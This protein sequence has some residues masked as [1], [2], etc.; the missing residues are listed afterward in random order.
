MSL[1]T[2]ESVPRHLRFNFA[3][4]LLDGAFFGLG[5]GFG[6]FVAIVPLFVHHLTKSALL[7][8]LVPAI[9][10][11]GWQLPQLLTAGWLTRAKRYKPLTLLMTVHE[12]VPF[13]GLSLL[14]L[15]VPQTSKTT[16][17]LLTF[18]MLVWQGLGAGMAANPWT[19]LVSKVIP[20]DLHGTFFG[21]QS[22]AFNGLAG[23]SALVASLILSSCG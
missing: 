11:M 3:V 7:I 9:H 13:L 14:A 22:A 6:S 8:G 17:L 4:G 12:R 1:S 18:G 15:L 16:I 20:Q 10:N 21:A 19:N 23:V 2:G 5:M